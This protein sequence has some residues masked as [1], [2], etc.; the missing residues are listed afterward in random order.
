L[1]IDA[2]YAPFKFDP[3]DSEYVDTLRKVTLIQSINTP[4][5]LGNTVM[6][7]PYLSSGCVGTS[8]FNSWKMSKAVSILVRALST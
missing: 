2:I 7:I 8:Y 6:K 4:G 1:I 3:D 5:V